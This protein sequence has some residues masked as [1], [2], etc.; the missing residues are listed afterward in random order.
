M[1]LRVDI[2]AGST[3]PIYRQVVDQIR[4]AVV[5]GDLEPGDP[6]P[7][8]RALAAQLVVNPNTI[9]KA[10]GELSRSGEIV[11]QR[12]RGMFIGHAAPTPN[13]SER[14]TRLASEAER[15]IQQALLLGASQAEVLA[16]IRETWSGLEEAKKGPNDEG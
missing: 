13:A 2:V 4:L 8:V 12:G 11:S 1:A 3:T 9:A 14:R 16:L 10:Y 5:T 6:L 15:L 7:S